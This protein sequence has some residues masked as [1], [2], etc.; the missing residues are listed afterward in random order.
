MAIAGFRDQEPV[1]T[2]TTATASWHLQDWW[3]NTGRLLQELIV[4]TQPHPLQV[5]GLL[6]ARPWGQTSWNPWFSGRCSTAKAAGRG[7]LPTCLKRIELAE[8]KSSSQILAARES[9]KQSVSACVIQEVILGEEEQILSDHRPS[10]LQS[11]QPFWQNNNNTANTLHLFYGSVKN[12]DLSVAPLVGEHETPPRTNT[13]M[14][15]GITL[16]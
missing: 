6:W 15:G 3:Q 10:S 16:Y 11:F 8:P 9:E 5:P 2:T 1:T 4:S 7:L 12:K 13:L 14:G